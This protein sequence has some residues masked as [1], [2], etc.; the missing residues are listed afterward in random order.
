MSSNYVEQV[1][2]SVVR[3]TNRIAPLKPK[4]DDIFDFCKVDIKKIFANKIKENNMKQTKVTIINDLDNRTCH[5]FTDFTISR[6]MTDQHISAI[7][8]PETLRFLMSLYVDHIISDL[9]ELTKTNKKHTKYNIMLR[10]LGLSIEREYDIA[11]E[12]VTMEI[13]YFVDNQ[14][15]KLVY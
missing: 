10:G 7:T 3:N 8:E 12:K 6:L 4:L 2:P 5:D 13:T 14:F 1:G 11:S 15:L 9:H